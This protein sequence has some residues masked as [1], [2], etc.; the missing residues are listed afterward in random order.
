MRRRRRAF[1][2][3]LGRGAI[4]ISAWNTKNAPEGRLR[5]YIKSRLAAGDVAIPQ[6]SGVLTGQRV[7]PVQP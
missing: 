3:E 7:R 6:S 1:A 2:R 5:R 4:G